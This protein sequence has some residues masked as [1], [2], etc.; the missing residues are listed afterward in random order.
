MF[1]ILKCNDNWYPLECLD[2]KED[3][4]A[5]QTAKNTLA[6]KTGGNISIHLIEE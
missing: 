1:A 6:K 4:V 5:A 3:I 2:I